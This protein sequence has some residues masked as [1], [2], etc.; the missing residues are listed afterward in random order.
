[1]KLKKI[2]FLMMTIVI[3]FGLIHCAEDGEI[4]DQG[5]E[6]PEGPAGP[7]GTGGPETYL[8]GDGEACAHCHA[9]TIA[10]WAHTNHAM[11]YDNLEE[12]DKSNLYCVKCHTT[13]F[14]ATVAYG[15]TAV[16][17]GNHGPDMYGFDDYIGLDTEEAVARREALANVQCE[18]CHGA[19]GP[20]DDL[21]QTH[22]KISFS[23]YNDTEGSSTSSCSPCHSGQLAE[24]GTSGHSAAGGTHEEFQSQHYAHRE[25]CQACH[26]SEGFIRATD[27]AY[28]NYDFGHEVSQI[29]CVTCHDPHAKL[30]EAHIRTVADVEVVYSPGY[31]DE[32]TDIPSMSGFG[33]GQLCAQCHHARRDNE[34]VTAQITAGSSHFGPHG[35]PQMD[36]FIGYGSYEIADMTYERETMHQTAVT[37]GCVSCHMTREAEIHGE[38]TMH[39]F[40]TF[41][42]DAGNCATCHTD[43]GEDF[44]YRSTQTATLALMDEL[45]V[46]LGF[47]DTEDYS[48]NFDSRADTTTEEMREAAYALQFVINDGSLG[49]HNS[50]YAQSLLNNAIDYLGQ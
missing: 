16:A 38:T 7:P 37:D 30:D 24:W 48:A 26:T 35:S 21:G 25:D 43:I 13:G 34:A 2:L 8:G 50:A 47:T 36:M 40:H 12:A 29:G 33:N 17:E 39:S 4:G 6:G 44:D 5:P 20:I 9:Q 46:A 1:M 14:D 27:Y 49:I 32:S 19:M 10:S 23:T 18:A 41:A 42:P 22:G 45:A 11:A 3:A 31:D 15:D 28:A